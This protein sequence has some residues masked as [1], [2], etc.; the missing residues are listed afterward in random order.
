VLAALPDGVEPG[1]PNYP[2]EILVSADGRFL[3]VSNRG[4]NTIAVFAIGPDP[5][6]LTLLWRRRPAPVTGRVTS[7]WTAPVGG[8][9][10][11]MSAP[12]TWSGY[13]STR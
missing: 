10:A 9:T 13:R 2:G 5:A 1:G 3:Y 6:D 8:C 11:P 7:P 12:V 4:S